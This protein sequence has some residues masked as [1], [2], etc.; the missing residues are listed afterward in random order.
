MSKEKT[1]K[2][3][4]L[5]QESKK[6]KREPKPS[7]NKESIA[8][9]RK[10]V[11][12]LENHCK[13]MVEIL[14]EQGA[15]GV[16]LFDLSDM[17]MIDYSDPSK[18]DPDKVNKFIEGMGY[19]VRFRRDTLLKVVQITSFRKDINSLYELVNKDE[20]F[21]EQFVEVATRI[22]KFI[23]GSVDV[24]TN[25]Q[26]FFTLY[27]DEIQKNLPVPY[28]VQVMQLLKYNDEDIKNFRISRAQEVSKEEE[29]PSVDETEP[30]F[31]EAKPDTD[32]ESVKE[33][34]VKDSE[35]V[36]LSIPKEV[37]ENNISQPE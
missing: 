8:M 33:I 21:S 4:H 18:N 3:N 26:K 5:N 9:S 6:K 37:I 27:K 17:Y 2:H 11:R 23:T 1:K 24:L 22:N 35:P 30:L 31:N 19:L 36:D 32:N 12:E 15:V 34:D 29:K 7:K 16:R 14:A 28:V 20:I 10:K 13:Q 25:L